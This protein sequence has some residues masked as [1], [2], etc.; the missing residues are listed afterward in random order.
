[1]KQTPMKQISKYIFS[2][3][4]TGLTLIGGYIFFYDVSTIEHTPVTLSREVRI[5]QASGDTIERMRTYSGSDTKWGVSPFGS[6]APLT[7][8]E[9]TPKLVF[10]KPNTE[11]KTR[12]VRLEDGRILRYVFGEGNP[13]EVAMTRKE[14]EENGKRC[15][16]L[17]AIGD[18]TGFCDPETG[19]L[20]YVSPEIEKHLLLALSDPNWIKLATECRPNFLFFEKEFMQGQ[21]HD[22]YSFDQVFSSGFLDIEILLSIEPKT[23]LKKL[24]LEYIWKLNNFLVTGMREWGRG[25]TLINPYG[26][27]VDRYGTEIVR[28]LSIAS[29]LY[30]T[31]INFPS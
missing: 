18:P 26:D 24:N 17:Y 31:P 3:S 4:L 8:T 16:T 29:Q 27:C 12:D 13:Q 2:I 25:E 30:R 11:W 5:A 10:Q 20:N 28:H 7:D 6:G 21:V 22:M 15:E 9:T 23:G 14:I 19:L 1:M